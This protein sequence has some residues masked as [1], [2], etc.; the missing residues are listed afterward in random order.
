MT[1][2]VVVDRAI[3][4]AEK[5]GYR[6]LELD[7]HRPAVDDGERPLVVNIHGGGWRMSH[8]G[9]APRET[10]SWQR[11]FHEQLVDAG[12]V[13]A[14]PSYRFSSEALFPAAIEDVTDAVAF[15]RTHADEFGVHAD[16][17]VLF[18]QSA[19]GYLAAAV[20]LGTAVAPVRAS[21]AG[22]P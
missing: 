4:Y 3:V 1:S 18:G 17:V 11:T 16:R 20:G 13:V 10:R 12:F 22:I 14:C 19:G 2:Q 5:P 7:L 8:R 9:R 6:A 21:C 15:L